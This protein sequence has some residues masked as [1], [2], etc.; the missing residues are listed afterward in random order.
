MVSEC[1]YV[2]STSIRR[3]FDVGVRCDEGNFCFIMLSTLS[4]SELY[5]LLHLLK[6]A[7]WNLSVASLKRLDNIFQ[8]FLKILDKTH[9]L[10]AV[11]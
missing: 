1:H 7:S 9:L 4:G 5:H 10:N 8:T 11:K 6:V 2:A 3:Q